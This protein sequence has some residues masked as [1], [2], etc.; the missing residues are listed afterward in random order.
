MKRK[1]A[2]IDAHELGMILDA[3]MYLID[4][5]HR[6]P[7]SHKYKKQVAWLHDRLLDQYNYIIK[8]IKPRKKK[9]KENEQ[10]PMVD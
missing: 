5:L 6:D 8:P 3:L 2:K 9:E 4:E 7:Y 10:I 1:L